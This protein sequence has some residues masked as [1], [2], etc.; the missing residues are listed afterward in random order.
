MEAYLQAPPMQG[1]GHRPNEIVET[2]LAPDML[3]SASNRRRAHHSAAAQGR[4]GGRLRTASPSTADY[5]GLQ[6]LV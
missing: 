4:D 3:P 5:A 6:R 1:K 2:K